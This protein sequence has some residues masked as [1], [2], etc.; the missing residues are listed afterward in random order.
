MKPRN[1]DQDF[2][3]IRDMPD[4]PD[5][6]EGRTDPHRDQDDLDQASADRRLPR[7]TRSRDMDQS[8]MDPS[9]EGDSER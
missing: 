5:A 7:P 2:D 3:L 9:G 1:N 8:G 6:I 4:D